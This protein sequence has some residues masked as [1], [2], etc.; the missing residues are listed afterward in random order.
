MSLYIYK[1]DKRHHRGTDSSR[2][3]DKERKAA[4]CMHKYSPE[5]MRGNQ[6]R[7]GTAYNHPRHQSH[8]LAYSCTESRVL[9]P[10]V[11]PEFISGREIGQLAL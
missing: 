1:A 8:I 11:I 5:C 2:P 6:E 9:D 4:S 3:E 7:E 10:T